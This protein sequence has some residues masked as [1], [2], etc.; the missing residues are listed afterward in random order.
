MLAFKSI[1]QTFFLV[2]IV[3]FIRNEIMTFEIVNSKLAKLL[4]GETLIALCAWVIEEHTSKFHFEPGRSIWVSVEFDY[5][6]R[7]SG[8]DDTG[9]LF[10]TQIH[11]LV[12]EFGELLVEFL[13]G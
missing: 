3:H 13:Y 2:Q 6:F 8:N 1:I 10:S 12:L 11:G 5:D 4:V 7:D 9:V